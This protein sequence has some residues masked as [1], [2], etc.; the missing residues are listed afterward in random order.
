MN[1]RRFIEKLQ[2]EKELLRVDVKVDTQLEISEIIDRQCKSES[3]GKAL[4]FTDNG[5]KFPLLANMMGSQK[6]LNMALRVNDLG[7][8][9]ERIDKLFNSAMSPKR[10]FME[11]LSL[12]PT[13]KEVSGFFPK[14][15]SKKGECQA[16]E[17][18]PDLS[19]LPVLKSAPYDGGRFITLPLVHTKDPDTGAQNV[20]MYRMQLFQN[21]TTGMHWHKHKTGASHYDKYK[22]R[23]E[24]MA[25][26]VCLGGDPLYT[27]CA[28]APLPEGIDEYILA[29]FLRKKSV[30]LVKCQTCDIEVPEDVDFVIEGYVDPSEDL[31]VEG[32][33]GDHTGFY[34]L[35][36]LYPKF[37]VTKITHRKDA[38]YPATIVG[39]PPMEDFYFA[40][41][42]ERI[43]LK[44]IQMVIAPEVVDVW[45]P[46]EG[47]AHNIVVVT[48][49]KRYEGQ[50]F[51]VVSALWG[52]GQMSFN[53]FCIVVDNAQPQLSPLEKV[54]EGLKGVDFKNDCTIVKGVLDV[55]DHAAGRVGYGGKMC[56]DLT[57]DSVDRSQFKFRVVHE[58]ADCED[59]D[60]V[61]VVDKNVP[62]DAQMSTIL[63]L[64]AANCDPSRDVQISEKKIVVDGRAK[65]DFLDR[66]PNI[67]C[68]SD[69]TIKLVDNRWPQYGVGAFIESPSLKLK[70]LLLSSGS[71]VVKSINV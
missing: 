47:V 45:M 7:E 62:L 31:V 40:L 36:D 25:V 6:R 41:A 11:K 46:M 57:N 38:V 2:A 42:S 23:G 24:K 60:A 20:G 34:S 14:H 32:D 17:I 39:V 50:A 12:L 37:H 13:L 30:K 19:L 8:I 70:P 10:T 71:T 48:I 54:L 44:P 35:K 26:V 61:L 53:K 18:D 68:Y 3:G 65:I 58:A 64:V 27:Y 5:T 1:L 63:W 56:L 15:L 59:C 51:K 69:E 29:G 22:E 55:L 4:L 66:H 21:N 33:F 67:V 9:N 28:T 43:F 16:F 52:A 49:D